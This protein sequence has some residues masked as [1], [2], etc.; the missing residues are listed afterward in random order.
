[1][2]EEEV[3][4]VGSDAF[5]KIDPKVDTKV[6]LKLNSDLNSDLNPNLKPKVNPKV[7][8]LVRLPLNLPLNRPVNPLDRVNPL[9]PLVDRP[10]FKGAK[11]LPTVAQQNFNYP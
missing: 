7:N 6:D 8:P 9:N 11:V 5:S 10:R 4:E 1:M 3:L 2:E